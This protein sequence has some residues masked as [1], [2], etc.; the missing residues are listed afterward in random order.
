M[1][2]Y[3]DAGTGG[4][5]LQVLLSG[6]VGG[7]VFFKLAASRVVDIVLRRAG[8][9]RSEEADRAEQEGSDESHSTAA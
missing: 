8:G 9:A 1:V 6:V 2:L 5:L 7:F 3:I 4:I